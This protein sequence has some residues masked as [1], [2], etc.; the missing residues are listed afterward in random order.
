MMKKITFETTGITTEEMICMCLAFLRC[1]EITDAAVYVA[2]DD[3]VPHPDDVNQGMWAATF[4]SPPLFDEMMG[5]YAFNRSGIVCTGYLKN[6][7]HKHPI[8]IM[9]PDDD[10]GEEVSIIVCGD[11]F[12]D[13]GLA[14]AILTDLFLEGSIILQDDED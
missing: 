8:T 5:I 9:I 2:A 3:Y 12:L 10:D 11:E 4:T 1:S 6:S 14:M 13:D 7:V